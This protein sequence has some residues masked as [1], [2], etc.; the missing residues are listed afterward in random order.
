MYSKTRIAWL[1]YQPDSN[2]SRIVHITYWKNTLKK[3]KE[4][5]VNHNLTRLILNKKLKNCSKS[6]K[7]SCYSKMSVDS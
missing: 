2:L 7:I 3:N 4:S 1:V 6:K 5:F